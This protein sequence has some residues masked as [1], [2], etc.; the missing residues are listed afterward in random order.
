MDCA[1]VYT[2]RDGSE[3][4]LMQKLLRMMHNEGK[5]TARLTKQYDYG[6]IVQSKVTWPVCV[7]E[8][9]SYPMSLL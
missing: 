4:Q 1:T 9:I 6:N 5:R 7:Q 2:T 3:Y 8:V